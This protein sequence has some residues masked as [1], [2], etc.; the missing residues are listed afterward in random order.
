MTKLDLI[1]KI[2][3]FS[4]ITVIFAQ[5]TRMP[6]VFCDT[7]TMDDYVY[8]YLEG[9]AAV[10]MADK[11]K[12]ENRPAQAVELKDKEIL[13]F[14]AEL[15]LLG[16][17]AVRFVTAQEDGAQAYLIQLT[18]FLRTPDLTKLPE[19]KR[20]VENPILQLSMLYF[21]QEARR[22]IAR[23]EKQGLKELEEES[24]INLVRGRFLMP[25]QSNP[26]E[27]DKKV[28]ML[29]KGN[30]EDTFVPLFTDG[31]EIRR[32]LKGNKSQVLICNFEMVADM[33][34]DGK[35]AGAVVNPA[36]CNLL[37]NQVSIVA[38]KD[39]FSE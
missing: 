28:V 39:R 15:H 27:P 24:S 8:V 2:P 30:Q 5:T 37:L 6:M 4:K 33:M 36:G 13:N 35:A 7:E 17:N 38:L 3:G 18:E 21:L 20:P 32:F 31:A 12:A 29:L 9:Q 22:P 19:E 10:E 11:L 26:D 23:E 14:M 25:V 16:V 1:N 34:R